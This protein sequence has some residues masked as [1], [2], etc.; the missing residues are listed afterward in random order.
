MLRIER[1][2]D[3]VLW[4]LDRPEAKNALSGELLGRLA[5]A[6]ERAGADPTVRAAILTGAGGAFASGGDLRELRD[7]SSP[8]DAA[9]LSDVG[10]QV[11]R[12]IG[13]LPFPVVAAIPGVAIGGGAELAIA[14]DLR[15][16]DVS[17][18]IC[19]KQA[20]MGATTAWGTLPRLCALVGPATAARL[21][22]TAQQ[23]SASAAL[24]LGLVDEVAQ[25]GAAL[26]TALAWCSDIA[27]G[28]PR[29]IAETKALLRAASA[30]FYAS[31]RA[32][33]REAFVRTWSSADHAEAMAAYFERRPPRWPG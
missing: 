21:L 29:A 15:I 10:E 26:L 2:G 3:I 33:E 16:A 1:E 5:Q 13:E 28:S 9:M 22:Y 27:A 7:K 30:S 19:L 12:R 8:A 23:T 6:I 31:M 17:A 14:C 11:C 32:L 4:T 20:R 18:R 24:V 25:D